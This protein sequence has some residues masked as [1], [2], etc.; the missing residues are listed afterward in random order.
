MTFEGMSYVPS[1]SVG[2][3]Q[4]AVDGTWLPSPEGPSSSFGKSLG[5]LSDVIF[6]PLE[7]NTASIIRA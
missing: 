4:G 7:V 2:T 3:A 5:V 6:F 1:S